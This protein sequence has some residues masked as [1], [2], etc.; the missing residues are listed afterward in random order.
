MITLCAIKII[1]LLSP[2]FY[3]HSAGSRFVYELI[4][5]LGSKL[6][7]LDNNAKVRP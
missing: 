4:A 7:F 6:G 2:V 5:L 1:I 3:W